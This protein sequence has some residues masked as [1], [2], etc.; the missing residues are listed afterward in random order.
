[1]LPVTT[2]SKKNVNMFN[3]EKANKVNDKPKYLFITFIVTLKLNLSK[4]KTSLLKRC[5][6]KSSP[7]LKHIIA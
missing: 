1:M 3:T 2:P 7:P 5:S 4:Q 6:F